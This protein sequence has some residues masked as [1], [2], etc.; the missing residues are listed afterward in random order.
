MFSGFI[1]NLLN[2]GGQSAAMQR[3][4][5]MNAHLNRLYPS[6]SAPQGGVQAPL[7]NADLP[8][9]LPKTFNEALQ[10]AMPQSV[11]F[12]QLLIN[13]KVKKVNAVLTTPQSMA[14]IDEVNAEIEALQRTNLNKS[15][16]QINSVSAKPAGKHQLTG[17]ISQICNKHGVDEKLVNALIKQESNYNPKATSKAGAMG[18][19]QL[20]PATAKGLG[21]KDPYNTV[22]NLDGGVRYLKSMLNKYNGNVILALAAYNAGPAAV[23]KY[24][25]VPPYN[26]TQQYVRK[27]LA[28]YL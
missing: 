9:N 14:D 3:A 11:N 23:D 17:L 10:S 15:I 12:G 4:A 2:T 26:E 5:Q 8:V 22:Q 7:T 28:N 13:P 21:V 25:G 18:L 24:D 20:M 6:A 1:Q 19:M 27:I 16:Q